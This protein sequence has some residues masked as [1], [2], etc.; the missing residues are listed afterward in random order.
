MVRMSDFDFVCAGAHEDAKATRIRHN[1]EL[2]TLAFIFSPL[3]ARTFATREASSKVGGSMRRRLECTA[4]AD[5]EYRRLH[6][7]P[8]LTMLI[9]APRRYCALLNTASPSLRPRIVAVEPA[10]P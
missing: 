5:E 9:W 8:Y 10:I 1:I 2:L 4:R 7:Y 3:G 6:Q